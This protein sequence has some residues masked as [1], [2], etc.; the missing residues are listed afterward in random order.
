MSVDNDISPTP[1]HILYG[2]VVHIEEGIVEW[3]T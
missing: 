2:A 3:T 1:A